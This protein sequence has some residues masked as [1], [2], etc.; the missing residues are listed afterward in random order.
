MLPKTAVEVKAAPGEFGGRRRG[1]VA[2]GRGCVRPAA[3]ERGEMGSAL[4]W[5]TVTIPPPLGM[6]FPPCLLPFC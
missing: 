2:L 5:L 1:G 3:A 6:G 4:A